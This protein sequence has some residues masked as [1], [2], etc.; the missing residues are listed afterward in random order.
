MLLF[1]AL[2]KASKIINEFSSIEFI[3]RCNYTI[4]YAGIIVSTNMKIEKDFRI[5]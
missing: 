3:F 2:I 1:N 4:F 5:L